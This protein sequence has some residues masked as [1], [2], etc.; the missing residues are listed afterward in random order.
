MDESQVSGLGALAA[1]ADAD[2]GNNSDRASDALSPRA[3]PPVIH[4]LNK[5]LVALNHPAA[6]NIDC[7]C[8]LDVDCDLSLPGFLHARQ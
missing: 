2:A 3:V 8:M 4:M 1:A 5:L 6:M 7:C